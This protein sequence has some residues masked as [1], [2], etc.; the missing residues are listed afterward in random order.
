MI[1]LLDFRAVVYSGRRRSVTPLVCLVSTGANAGFHGRL[2]STIIMV[3]PEN[4]LHQQPAT[5]RARAEREQ[6]A[7]RIVVPHASHV[8][9]AQRAAALGQLATTVWLTGL[10]GSGKSTIATELEK[11]LMSLGRI[12]YMLDGDNVRTGINRDLG[13]GHE[14]RSENIRRIAEVARLMNDAGLIVV[15]AFISPYREDRAMARQIIGSDRFV[16]VHLDASLEVCERRDPKGL[17]RKARRGE[18]PEFTG[19][20]APYEAPERPEIV[21]GTGASSVEECIEALLAELLPRTQLP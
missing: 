1:T 10:S 8:T 16:E 9:Q 4:N 2:A 3:K 19:I 12:C 13:F 11:R 20:S 7:E 17:Y 5:Q 18:I 15:T 14:D 21:L 6:M